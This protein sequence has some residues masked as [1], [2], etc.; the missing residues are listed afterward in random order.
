MSEPDDLRTG[1]GLVG[2]CIHLRAGH[3]DVRFDEVELAQVEMPQ[4]GRVPGSVREASLHDFP[5]TA[6]REVIADE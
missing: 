5:E 4:D 3:R 2:I 1:E 6:M